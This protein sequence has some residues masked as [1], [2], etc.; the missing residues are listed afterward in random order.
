[1]S[2]GCIL[3]TM[4]GRGSRFQ[5]VGINTPKH[6]IQVNGK[7]LFQW[8]MESLQSFFESW[9]FIFV[10]LEGQS[11]LI[12]E[13]CESVGIQDFAI[14][15]IRQV[16]SGQAET[17]DCAKEVVAP[18]DPILI[19]N[20]D[21]HVTPGQIKPDDLTDWDG[22]LHIF[23]GQGSHWSFVHVVDHHR[24]VQVAEKERISDLCSVG[25]YFFRSFE[26]FER[27]F[28]EYK[29]INRLKELY[30]APMY[31]IAIDDGLNIGA[32]E[33]AADAVVPLGT[34]DEVADVDSSFL[35]DAQP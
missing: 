26:L 4:A 11:A 16:T 31:Q 17:A 19:Y 22:L 8:S 20:I 21:T 29:K 6:L 14:V 24:V 28:V 33:V 23:R 7:S 10:I 9:R 12:P 18:T 3:V 35:N 13:L 2:D 5:R 15:P 34:P 25:S 1:M 30:V 27:L 32:Q